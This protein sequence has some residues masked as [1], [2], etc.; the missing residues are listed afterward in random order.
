M[1]RLLS[2]LFV[3]AALLAASNAEARFGKRNSGGSDDSDD[4][5]S[6]SRSHAA[7]PGSGS[8]D[9]DDSS[10]GSSRSGRYHDASPGS[11]SDS[12]SS[13]R[14]WV[15]RPRCV[16][17]GC[18]RFVW[19]GYGYYPYYLA[20]SPDGGTRQSEVAERPLVLTAGVDVQAFRGG[21]VGGLNLLIEGKRFG[22]MVDY[23][24]IVVGTDDGSAGVDTIGLLAFDLSWAPVASPHGR[25]RLEGGVN[26][27][28]APDVTFVGP[29]LGVSGAV[30]LVGTLNAEAAVRIT[31][32]PH[33]QVDAFGGLALGLG[34]L[35]LRAGYKR[36]LLDDRGLLDG[37]RHV[38]VF[39][40]PYVGLAL[41]L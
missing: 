5:S 11:S 38:D 32:L 20:P 36:I 34:H 19:T 3:A 7:S 12:E 37:E 13:G 16:D 4:P 27:A 14:L 6:S 41:S 22:F 40:G 15:A 29:H 33:A 21:G 25:L 17:S 31:P 23:Q 9:D 39:S 2:A 10:A 1:T 26:F 24:G 18:S 28:N 35:G 30:G 8:L